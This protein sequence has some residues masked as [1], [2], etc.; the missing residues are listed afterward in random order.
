MET[1]KEFDLAQ[2]TLVSF[3]NQT[4]IPGDIESQ[5]QDDFI[6]LLRIPFEL[7]DAR[8]DE[9]NRLFVKG[10]FKRIPDKGSKAAMAGRI[11]Y[12]ANGE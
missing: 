5:N 8:K 2:N 3:L 1:P 11:R 6:K 12:V 4:V 9:L 10:G 7:L